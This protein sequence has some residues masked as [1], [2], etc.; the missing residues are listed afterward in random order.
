MTLSP[1]TYFVFQDLRMS[2]C[3]YN[4]RFGRLTGHPFPNPFPISNTEFEKLEMHVLPAS[5]GGHVI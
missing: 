5:I 2:L 3:E 4:G 1:S